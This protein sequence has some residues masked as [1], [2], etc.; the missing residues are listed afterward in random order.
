[1]K[2]VLREKKFQASNSMFG[3]GFGNP[4]GGQGG[5]FGYNQP[6]CIP[7]SISH[8]FPQSGPAIFEQEYNCYPS[9]F[10]GRDEIDKGNKII[11]PPSALDILARLNISYP[12]LFEVCIPSFFVD[13]R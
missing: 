13:D 6:V 5:F 10:L 11:L 9:S 12:M 3:W 7:F 2:N 1:M 4:G 8:I